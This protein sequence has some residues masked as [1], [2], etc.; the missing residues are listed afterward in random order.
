MSNPV[1]IDA[2]W[3]YHGFQALVIENSH[4]R[5]VV[6]PELGGKLW[7]LVYKPIDRE[8]FWHNPRMAPRPAFYGAAYDDWFC[9]GWDELFPNDAPTSFAGDL[10]PDHGEWWAMPFAWEIATLRADEVT[11]HLWR[12]GIVTNTRVERWIT[13]RGDEARVELRYRL[14]NA[15]PQPLDFLW[16][17]HPALAISPHAR[18]ELP[19]CAVLPEPAFNDR[20]DKQPFSWPHARSAQGDPVDMRV[21]PAPDAATCDFYYAT[22][23]AAGWCALTDTQAGYRCELH[24]DPAVFRS[25]WV[26]GAYGGWRGHYVTILEPCTGYPYRLEDAVAQGAASRLA[27]GEEIET[28]VRLE[29]GD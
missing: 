14:H 24:F 3:R 29:I 19:A 18:I 16:K 25:V 11:V 2:N 6:L 7:S 27:A 10:Y 17:L 9:G 28:T 20:L 23:L 21:V 8:I 15:G 13:V 22:D 5:L 12:A 4:L 1:R 26:F